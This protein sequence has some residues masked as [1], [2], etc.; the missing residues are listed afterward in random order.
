[1]HLG[2]LLTLIGPSWW[3][4]F[5]PLRIS[6]YLSPGS[7]LPWL[8]G[9]IGLVIV[10]M[11]F[12]LDTYQPYFPIRNWLDGTVHPL[13]FLLVGYTLVWMI[14]SRSW[15]EFPLHRG[16]HVHTA[17]IRLAAAA[18]MFVLV[19]LSGL[20]AWRQLLPYFFINQGI[21][22]YYHEAY[23]KTIDNMSRALKMNN[24]LADGY[25]F[26]ALAHSKLGQHQEALNDLNRLVDGP[27]EKMVYYYY[28]RAQTLKEVGNMPAACAD[29]QTAFSKQRWKLSPGVYQRAQD[30]WQEWACP[31]P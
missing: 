23:L 19:W 7:P 5:S 6:E 10:G 14:R 11:A 18:G 27:G 26:R 30:F 31:P 25:M 24:N 2:L 4:I 28:Y 17:W 8:A 29:L 9:L 15:Q 20:F 3:L 22:Q 16:A 13:G 1:M 21:T 12:Y